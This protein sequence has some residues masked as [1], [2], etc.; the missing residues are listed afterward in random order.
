MT[1][2]SSERAAATTSPSTVARQSLST[3][4]MRRPARVRDNCSPAARS[5]PA[6]SVVP[7]PRN[8]NTSFTT[9]S[10]DFVE[11][12]L[13]ATTTSLPNAMTL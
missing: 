1:T 2:S 9:C 11:F 5:A 7:N 12:W 4:V 10:P 13:L 8:D 3:T 6:R